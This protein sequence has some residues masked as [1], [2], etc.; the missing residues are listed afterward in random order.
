MLAPLIIFAG[1]I[2]ILLFGQTATFK[3]GIVGQLYIVLTSLIFLRIK[4]LL[5]KIFGS[6]IEKVF[7]FFGNKIRYNRNPMIL[8]FYL[9][10]VSV[11]VKFWFD[12][13]TPD[14]ATTK[15]LDPYQNLYLCLYLF[16][17]M[18]TFLF[19]VF[20]KPG[21]VTDKNNEQYLKRYTFDEIL[22][23][24][25]QCETCKLI[26]PARSKHCRLLNRCVARYDHYCAWLM[27]T[28]GEQNYRYFILFLFANLFL[29]SFGLYT[30]VR[31]LEQKVI[32]T[33]MFELKF[34]DS[35]GNDM[36]IGFTFMMNYLKRTQPY[37]LG[38]GYLLISLF[39]IVILFIIYHFRLIWKNTTTNESVKIHELKSFIRNYQLQETQRKKGGHEE[40]TKGAE[41]LPKE[42]KN[43]KG[44]EK[45]ESKSKNVRK[46]NIKNRTNKEN[47]IPKNNIK[48]EVV[49]EKENIKNEKAESNLNNE[50]E[51]TKLIQH[52][53]ENIEKILQLNPKK[54]KS[55]YYQ[56]F[57]SNL[58]DIF[59]PKKIKI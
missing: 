10:M 27:N 56:G 16:F 30:V 59:F 42:E 47:Q 57:W 34:R 23:F 41:K 6:R 38:F 9:L 39:V 49:K 11:L 21:F 4:N 17:V 50:I 51:K 35:K 18:I 43:N 5:I 3:D 31:V 28:M 53:E 26:K 8:I 22:F 7:D 36:D 12:N 37:T 40:D 55:F 29:V 52:W 54:F 20:T 25:E 44:I 13:V 33:K 58:K 14:F 46:R 1:I 19:G 45:N 15:S 32:N 48:D 2:F 24:K